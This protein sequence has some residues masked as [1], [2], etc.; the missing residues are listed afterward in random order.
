[1]NPNDNSSFYNRGLAYYGVEQY[2]KSLADY[3]TAANQSPNK[4]AYEDFIKYF[5]EKRTSDTA[6]TRGEII[7]LLEGKLNIA[8]KVAAPIAAAKPIAVTVAAPIPVVEPVAVAAPAAVSLAQTSDN[9]AK[10][11]PKED[12]Q[13]LVNKWLTSWKSGDMENYRNCYDESTF[14]SKK[15]NLSDWVSYKTNVR[16]KSKNISISIDDLQISADA[17]TATAVFTQN[18][19][20]SILK[21]SGKKTLKLKKVNDQWKIYKEIM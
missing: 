12:V 1:M 13:K 19:S 11:T 10:S 6:N 21:D 7:R 8:K 18:Y 5:P 15:M 14:Q 16:N 17:N 20:S 2:G 3:T 4:G 9:Q